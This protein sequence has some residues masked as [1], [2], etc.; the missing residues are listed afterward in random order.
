MHLGKSLKMTGSLEKG[1]REGLKGS[2]LY[3]GKDDLCLCEKRYQEFC[4]LTGRACEA[5]S[6]AIGLYKGQEQRRQSRTISISR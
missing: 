1:A 2:E 3:K 4:I 5:Y 6:K